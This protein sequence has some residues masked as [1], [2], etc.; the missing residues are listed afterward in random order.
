MSN[1]VEERAMRCEC[2]IYM[3]TRIADCASEV[4]PGYVALYAQYIL[5]DCRALERAY[6]ELNFKKNDSLS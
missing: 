6:T 2:M 4:D 5:D 1:D 3:L